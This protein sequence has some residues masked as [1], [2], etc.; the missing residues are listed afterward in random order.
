MRIPA[1]TAAGCG[2]ASR[3]SSMQPKQM[4]LRTDRSRVN[5]GCVRARAQ[6]LQGEAELSRHRGGGAIA[7]AGPP[8]RRLI[9]SRAPSAAHRRSRRGDQSFAVSVR[10][11]ARA[12]LPDRV[13]GEITRLLRSSPR[14][15]AAEIKRR[16]DALCLVIAAALAV[17]AADL[18]GDCD[19]GTA[20]LQGLR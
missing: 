11:V 13:A 5:L 3:T 4:C 7:A 10:L 14:A 17:I 1:R 6:E 9:S 2:G 18:A 8:T 15:G 12:S 16:H 20:G 19:R